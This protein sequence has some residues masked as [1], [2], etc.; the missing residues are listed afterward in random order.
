MISYFCMTNIYRMLI[1]KK[2]WWVALV[3]IL[4]GYVLWLNMKIKQL[5]ATVQLQSVELSM[6][7]DSVAIYKS[8]SGDLT[9][10]INSVEVDN[11]N[12]KKALEIAGYN[13]KKLKE[14]DIDSKNIISALRAE[15]LAAGSGATTIIDTCYIFDTDTIQFSKF[16]WTNDYLSLKGKIVENSMTFDYTYKTDI[17]VIQAYKRDEVIVNISLTDPNAVITTGRSIT[18][19][20][21]RKWWDKPIVWGAAGIATGILISK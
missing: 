2:Y 18:V 15:L 20:N 9:Y 17:N 14:Q 3:L 8:K 5:D 4:A 11:S 6:I 12:L 1:V 13:V 19:K 10:K 7:N 21:P 16:K